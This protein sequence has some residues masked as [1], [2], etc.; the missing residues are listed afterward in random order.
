LPLRSELAMIFTASFPRLPDE[1]GQSWAQ[2]SRRTILI[3]R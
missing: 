1:R 2:M 3:L